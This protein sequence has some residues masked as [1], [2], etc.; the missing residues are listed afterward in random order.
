MLHLKVALLVA[1]ALALAACT[2]S[3]QPGV[4]PPCT[5][6]AGSDVDPCEPGAGQ[7]TNPTAHGEDPGDEPIGLRDYMDGWY[8]TSWVAHLVVR[9]TYLPGTVRCLSKSGYR[10]PPFLGLE[11]PDYAFRVQCF[12]DVRVN[13]YILGDGP[14]TLTVSLTNL[15][16]ATPREEWELARSKVERVLI[17]GGYAAM[18]EVPEGGIVGRE[19]VMWVGPDR[20]HSTEVMKAVFAWD[21]I[22]DGATVLVAHPHRDYWLRLR[23][24]EAHRSRVEWTLPAFTQAIAATNQARIAEYGGRIRQGDQYPMLVTDANHLRQFYIDTGAYDH[25]DGP[26]VQPLPP[27]G[28]AV[29]DQGANPGLM[30][31]CIALLAARDALRGA[32]TL[33]WSTDTP[34][35]GW[36]GVLVQGKP[37][38]VQELTLANLG[39]SG[40]IPPELGRLDD[41]RRLELDGNKLTGPIPSELGDLAHLHL[42]YLFDNQLTGALPASLGRLHRL[43]ALFAQGNRLSGTIPPE[44]GGMVSLQ[45]LLLSDNRLTRPIPSGLSGLRGLSEL[46]LSGNA[47]TGAIPSWLSEL[48]ALTILSLR[49]NKLTGGI[50]AGLGGLSDLQDLY[51]SGNSLTGCIPPALRSV[52]HHDLAGLRLPD[53][54]ADDGP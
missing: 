48:S 52:P 27:C 49:D 3:E 2:G 25:P 12:A 6:V 24:L 40:T 47:L 4:I 18:L 23:G 9:A 33:N 30:Q 43:E 45:Q 11:D 31:D 19:K 32:A 1:V 21:V 38:R 8:S 35:T 28:L 34:I 53:C 15:I 5:P 51:L 29:P 44:L 17:E 39:L 22:R 13:D 54:A 10:R 36:Q 14:D 46:W 37:A 20:E 26:P 42:L 50:P 16:Y 41:L 7:I